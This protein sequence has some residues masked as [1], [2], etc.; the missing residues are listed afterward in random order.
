MLEDASAFNQNL[1]PWLKWVDKSGNTSGGWCYGAICDANTALFPT[2]E[3]SA[4]PS[5]SIPP[6]ENKCIGLDKENCV[7][8]A[9]ICKYSSKKKILGECQHKK[10]IYRHDCAQY[11]SS[12]SCLSGFYPG[13]CM[14]N[15]KVCSHVCDGLSK[16]TCKKETYF[17]DVKI[18][19]MPK[20]KNPCLGCHLKSK[21]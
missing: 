6:A 12:E 20:I 18:C 21:C 2:T 7:S 1:D 17:F 16:K 13:M 5:I 3:P 4:F 19:T 11:T 15:G 14:W 8:K 9:D 10:D